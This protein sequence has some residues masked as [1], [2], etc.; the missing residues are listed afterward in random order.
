MMDAVI[1]ITLVA[2]MTYADMRGHKYVP[3]IMAIIL[4]AT[5]PL[6]SN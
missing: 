5:L 2:A 4:L 1:T 3:V 6:Y